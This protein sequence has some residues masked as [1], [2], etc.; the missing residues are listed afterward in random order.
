[1]AS[2]TLFSVVFL[3]SFLS[4][5]TSRSSTGVSH[6]KGTRH[7][8]PQ[9]RVPIP[10]PTDVSIPAEI[11][12]AC[13]ATRFTQACETS[14]SGSSLPDN[15]KPVDLISAGIKLSSE[16]VKTAQSMVQ[17]ILDTAGNDQ[18]RSTAAKNCL[19]VIS[20]SQYRIYLA[21]AALDR[22][23]DARAWMSAALLYQQGCGSALKY[24][25]TTQRVN[26]TMAYLIELADLTS[27]ML[28]MLVS[29][30]LYGND[31]A[32]WRP[33]ETERDGFWADAASGSGG[34][35]PATGFRGG[36]P[37]T[38]EADATVCKDGKGC[39]EN[40][41]DA[42]K[43]APENLVG[44][45]FVIYIKEGLYKEI[46]RIPLEKK[47]LVFLGDGMG[48]TVITGDLNAQMV[49]VSTYNTAT[50]GVAGDGFM[51]KDITFSNA[52]GPDEH[53]AV[54]FRSTSDFSV[55]Q[56][57]EFLGHQDTLYAHSLRQFYK[58]C[59]IAGTVDFIFGNSASV[60]EDCLIL[61]LP[62]Q[63][64]PEQG[65]NNAVTAHGRTDPAQSTGF[66]FKD[67]TINGTDEY[68]NLYLK[69]PKVHKNFL[70][71]PWKEYSRTVYI[72]CYLG[73]LIRPEGWM[74]WNQDF[75]LSTLY[76]GEFENTGSGAN[77]SGRVKWSNQI[78]AEHVG[79]Y[80]VANFIQ[81]DEWLPSENQ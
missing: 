44:R 32:S 53:Q 79:V 54:A 21:S 35:G 2:L 10:T 30:D 43:A 18:N 16:N 65:E 74:P 4:A 76:Y 26:Q 31:T 78:P 63:I 3:F 23:K 36:F 34:R 20:Y 73:P 42:V 66:V 45:R 8:G 51:A 12:N 52:A 38:A 25:N 1:M 47:N 11:Q 81:G 41:Q 70:G 46:V 56:N 80:S 55:L 19:E 71:R 59:R 58:S 62:R 60:F 48:K 13:K 68:M 27:N 22:I 9:K 29:Y 67:C 7:T 28:S 75:A 14:L 49:G 64:N 69:N 15:P 50:V 77:T 57:C 72:H 33:P 39:Y 5:V 6:V 17:S 40:I 61:V 24:V 37:T